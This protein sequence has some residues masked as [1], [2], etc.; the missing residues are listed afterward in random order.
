MPLEGEKVGTPGQAVSDPVENV[1]GA[2]L[3]APLRDLGDL[4][5]VRVLAI[6]DDEDALSLVRVVLEET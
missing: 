1:N 2:E 4:T 6:D 5:G 3:S